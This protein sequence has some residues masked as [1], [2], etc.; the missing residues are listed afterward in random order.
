M[1]KR[2]RTERQAEREAKAGEVVRTLKDG[3]IRR[4]EAARYRAGFGDGVRIAVKATMS[5]FV[6]VL[7]ETRGFD[8]AACDEVFEAAR[9]EVFDLLRAGDIELRDLSDFAKNCGV[10]DI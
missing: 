6:T 1:G 5:A 2:R 9:Q 4:L 7:A 3:E 10:R 8:A